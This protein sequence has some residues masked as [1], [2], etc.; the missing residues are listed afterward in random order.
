MSPNTVTRSAWAER[1]EAEG[2]FIRKT[3]VL[4]ERN[5]QNST[6]KYFAHL[7]YLE[8]VV[9]E[10]SLKGDVD[11]HII[12]MDILLVKWLSLEVASS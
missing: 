7:Q 8:G 10:Q 11:R 3:I 4:P 6:I 2:L 12:K 5:D 9:Q 1:T